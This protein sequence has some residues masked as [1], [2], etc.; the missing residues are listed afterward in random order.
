MIETI[1]LLQYCAPY[2]IEIIFIFLA[3]LYE[4][5]MNLDDTTGMRDDFASQPLVTQAMV[6]S[7][8]KLLW[9]KRPGQKETFIIQVPNPGQCNCY[10]PI[11]LICSWSYYHSILTLHIPY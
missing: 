10:F 7:G 9:P 6:V 11:S 4:L 1:F 8:G 2:D 3:S 5:R